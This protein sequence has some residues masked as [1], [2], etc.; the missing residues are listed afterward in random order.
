MT[1]VFKLAQDAYASYQTYKAERGLMDFTDQEVYALKALENPAICAEL[2][3]R[4]DLVLVDEFQDTS[5]MQLAIFLKLAQ[6]APRSI[7]VGDQ[8]QAIYGFR[9]T[10]PAL[11]AAAIAQL[12]AERLPAP[13]LSGVVTPRVQSLRRSFRSRAPLVRLTSRL[14]ARAFAAHGISEDRVALDAD[15]P[16]DPALGPCLEHWAL[17]LEKNT[18]TRKLPAALAAGV[19]QLLADPTVRVR[20][21]GIG[22]P[23][24]VKRADVAILCASNDAC[25]GVAAALTALGIPS[26]RQQTGVLAILEGCA[27][28]AALHLWRD[29]SAPR[30]RCWFSHSL[31]LHQPLYCAMGYRSTVKAVV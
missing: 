21:R 15:G 16:D 5:P 1:L 30:A 6:L 19:H 17:H 8:K 13:G 25:A 2:R 24:G 18:Q 27:L 28:R 12:K 4:L 10:D 31:R 3:H 26:Q 7:W 11:M 29:P 23:R 14:F 22:R 9:G 20:D